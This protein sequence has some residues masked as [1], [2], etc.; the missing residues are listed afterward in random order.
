MTKDATPDLERAAQIAESHNAATSVIAAEI[1]A[2]PAS[3]EISELITAARFASEDL[4]PILEFKDGDRTRLARCQ[5]N[6]GKSLIERNRKGTIMNPIDMN[7]NE[8]GDKVPNTG[9]PDVPGDTPVCV[10]LK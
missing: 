3:P 5:H 2:L 9:K 8:W 10:W 6:F 7:D 1:R 4:K